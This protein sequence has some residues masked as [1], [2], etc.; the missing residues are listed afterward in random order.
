MVASRESCNASNLLRLRSQKRGCGLHCTRSVELNPDFSLQS[1]CA[2]VR[3]VWF[4]K[5]AWQRWSMGRLISGS[6][7][8]S[9]LPSMVRQ[10][11]G[12]WL[13]E[14]GS[15]SESNKKEHPK[16]C[17]VRPSLECSDKS[18]RPVA[19]AVHWSTT[20][21]TK[22]TLAESLLQLMMENGSAISHQVGVE[23]AG[24]VQRRD[25]SSKTSCSGLPQ[26]HGRR[27]V[28]QPPQH[29]ERRLQ[30]ASPDGD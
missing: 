21:T 12:M 29:E 6:I 3:C 25:A 11:V 5:D 2:C 22:V 26:S 30:F 19:V 20:T 10:P 16:I 1:P 4:L 7:T 28:H 17:T 8:C 13:V 18:S 14:L 23:D 24:A 15:P 9:V 27:T